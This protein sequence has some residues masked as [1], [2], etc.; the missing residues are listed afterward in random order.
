[1]RSTHTRIVISQVLKPEEETACVEVVA[2]KNMM[3]HVNV[4]IN[5]S[6]MTDVDD[7]FI[8]LPSFEQ[9][10]EAVELVRR[11]CEPYNFHSNVRA[12]PLLTIWFCTISA[13]KQ[14]NADN[15]RQIM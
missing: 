5:F 4:K 9:Q 15:S 3:E 2:R 10:L 11:I 6:E 8:L 1:M 7:E 14:W 12:Q 13:N